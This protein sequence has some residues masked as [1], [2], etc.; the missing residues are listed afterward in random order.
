MGSNDELILR[1]EQP[2][3]AQEISRVVRLAFENSPHSD[4]QEHF[5]VESLRDSGALDPAVIAQ[6]NDELVGFAGTSPVQISDGSQG[7]F[8]LGPVAVLTDFQGAGIGSMIVDDILSRLRYRGA[9]GCVVLGDPDF[10]SRFGFEPDR[11][12]VFPGFD[13]EYFQIIRFDESPA[14][15]NVLYHPAFYSSH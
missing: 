11:Q 4:Q 2:G 6:I 3:D 9:S 15:G 12:L 5:I 14:H 13:P 10:Y 8:G 7:W 1:L